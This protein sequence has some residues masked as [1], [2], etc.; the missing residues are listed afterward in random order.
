M[1]AILQPQF[2]ILAA[3]LAACTRLS[4]L[5]PHPASA[6][7]PV[8]DGFNPGANARVLSVAVQ[9]GGKILLGGGFTTLGGQTRKYIGR[10]NAD[11][12]LDSG[13]N[14]GAVN[15]VLSL[16]LQADEKILV[17]VAF[18]AGSSPWS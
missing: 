11:G 17:G 6:Q 4:T 13:F 5:I 18:R 2:S 12:T 15:W 1:K 14:P 7:S 3:A 16:A 8:P 10:L 9:A